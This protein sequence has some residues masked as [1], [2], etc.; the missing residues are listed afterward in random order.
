LRAPRD[1]DVG[2]IF[3]L[4]FPPFRGGPFRLVDTMGPGAVLRRMRDYEQAHG[5]RFTPA[6]VLV[7]MVK[8][9]GLFY[10]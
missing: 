2:A 10:G 8:G 5:K 4:G 3:G 6:P 9:N 1:G 7:E